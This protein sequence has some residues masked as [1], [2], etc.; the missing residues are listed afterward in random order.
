MKRFL[1]LF[2]VAILAYASG[3]SQDAPDHWETVV[4]DTSV[5]KY[6]P[7]IVEPDAS[8]LSPDF[9]DNGWSM[10]K[11]GFGYGDGDDSTIVEN[12]SSI[13]IRKKFFIYDKNDILNA[14][15]HVD[16]DDGF[17]A[18]LNGVEVARANMAQEKPSHAD[19]SITWREPLLFL[20]Q[21]AEAFSLTNHM[22]LL[23]TG[24]NLLAIQ[25][26]N[27]DATSSDLTIRPFLSVGMLSETQTYYPTPEWFVPPLHFESSNLPILVINTN[28]LNITDEPAIVANL[29]VI[30]NG[31]GNRNYLS[32]NFNSYDGKISIEFRGE[33]SQMFDKKSFKVKTIDDAGADKT[34]SLLGLPPEDD[35]VLYAPYTDKTMMRNVLTYGLGNELGHYATRT[36]YCEVVINGQYHGVYVLM[37]KIKQDRNRVDIAKLN[38]DDVNG[39]DLTGG[40]ILR[41]DKIDWTDYPAWE[42]EPA[43]RLPNENNISFQFFDPDGEDLA[44]AQKEY[45]KNFIFD[46]QSSLTKSTFKDPASGY[47]KYIDMNSFVDFML[48]NEFNKNVDAYIYSTYMHKEKDSDGGKLKMGP[49]WD[50]NLAFGNVDYH[51]NSQYAPGWMYNDGYRMFWFRRLMQDATFK[52]SVT[53]RWLELRKTVFNTTYI[54]NWIDSTAAVLNEA[55]IR[56]YQ[57]W[58]ILGKYVWPNQFVGNT[59]ESELDFL[60][61]WIAARI[62]WMDSNLP[63][64]CKE[65]SPVVTDVGEEILQDIHVFPNPSEGGF[66]FQIASGGENHLSIFNTQGKQVFTADQLEKEFYWNASSNEGYRLPSGLYIYK[67]ANGRTSKIGKIIIE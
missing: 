36:K 47:K 48:I 29:G 4:Y 11:G 32:D 8:W 58:P 13:Y 35:W 6:F 19:F 60:K 25:V 49:I 41:V 37:E 28:G 67:I 18:Y 34:V 21:A 31:A 43:P 40:Y 56:N 5:W 64:T 55:Q 26:H 50:F 14:L 7:G 44:E 45:I 46:F 39:D 66:H 62:T 54:N 17:V 9:D 27:A 24:E 30:D 61:Q 22:D 65:P 52:D 23:V 42:S 10:G 3:F 33:S 53:C 15:L 57:R 59:Y 1:L 38:P 20:G 16:Y 63:K 2:S 12:V 51:T